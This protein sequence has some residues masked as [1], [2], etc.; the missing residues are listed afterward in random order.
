[1][2]VLDELAD[3]SGAI[4]DCL[5]RKILIGTNA[6]NDF[7]VCQ[8]HALQ[9]P[10]LAHEVFIRRNLFFLFLF[11]S[12]Y[13]AANHGNG[14]RERKHSNELSTRLLITRF[15]IRHLSLHLKLSHSLLV[16]EDW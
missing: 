12:R 3:D 8:K 15:V 10:V 1:M 7:V 9:N 5:G 14:P 16:K 2:V 6:A 11:L 4:G 13:W